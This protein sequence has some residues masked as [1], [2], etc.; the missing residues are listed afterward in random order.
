MRGQIA[1]NE[2]RLS[3]DGLD[4]VTCERVR[5]VR[6]EP[7]LSVTGLG[8]VYLGPPLS[9]RPA[10]A[11]VEARRGGRGLGRVPRR[12]EAFHVPGAAFPAF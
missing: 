8:S 2:W 3:T 12:A 4:A 1:P 9:P 10:A 5:G 11:R 6:P 7:R